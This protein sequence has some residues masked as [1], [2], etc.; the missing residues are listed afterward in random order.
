MHRIRSTIPLDLRGERM[1]KIE[2]LVKYFPLKSGSSIKALDIS[3]LEIKKGER[4]GLLGKSGSGKTT[5]LRILRGV[6]HFDE[7]KVIIDGI[8]LT[9]NSERD[10]FREVRKRTAIHLQRSFGLWSEKVVQNVIR[11]LYYTI[12]GDEVLPEE[13]TSLYEELYEK[14]MK[15]LEL[16][17]LKHKAECWAE[18]LSGGEKQRLVLAR[19]LAKNPSILL[20]DEFGTMT[21]PETRRK[22]I[23]ILRRA[24][25]E[26]GVTL[27][28]SS[29]MPEIHKELAKRVVLL[30]KG[31]VIASGETEDVL[32]K[33][34]SEMEP[35]FSKRSKIGKDNVRADRVYKS[36]YVIPGGKTL[37]LEDVVFSIKR[38]QIVGILG[39]S[40]SGKTVIS[41]I[42]AG[43]E[44]P[45]KGK[46]LVRTDEK[47][48]DWSTFGNES[49]N[50]RRKIGILHQEFALP[51]WAKVR[52]LISYRIRIKREEVVRE[53]E[54]RATELGISEKLFDAI[55]RMTDLPKEEAEI[56]L[57]RLGLSYNIIKE[58]FPEAEESITDEIHEILEGL[59]LSLEIL[60]RYSH[61][62][63]GGEAVRLGIALA[64]M[65]KPDI[66]ILD[67]PFGDIDPV[68]LRKVSNFLKK[69]N[70]INGTTIIII[71]HQ[72]DLVREMADRIL[73]IKEGKLYEE[74]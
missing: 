63:S 38:G 67:E 13:D 32:R 6:E 4:V 8:E 54:K 47:W 60:D 30:D 16:V 39:R 31:K 59:D 71:S 1:I 5:L 66:L 18:V 41:R 61:E 51:Y 27:V 17:D 69:F 22:C 24:N 40:G 37:E 35:S 57:M 62:L 25:E 12:W 74:S 19:Q 58:L 53:A 42:I 9:P 68:T 36:Y 34:L 15:L 48:V 50:A 10:K 3:E 55:Y 21:C 28:F 73:V 65:T 52:D 72:H 44:L 20:V 43:L 26:M 56:R 11:A 14:A 7:G 46:V 45:D 29:H 70:S 33:F 2:N 23:E 49:V 64:V